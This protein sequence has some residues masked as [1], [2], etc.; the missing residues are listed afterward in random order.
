[1]RK[2]DA[3]ALLIATM[4]KHGLI[5]QG[6]GIRWDRAKQRAG[7]CNY[8]YRRISLS[9]PLFAHFDESAAT[10]VILHEVAHALTP[11]HGHD[12]VWRAKCIAIGGDGKRCC[13][14]VAA[15]KAIAKYEI[16]CS[17]TGRSLGFAN[18]KGKRLAA[19]RCRCCNQPPLWITQN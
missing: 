14:E 3:Q 18:R 6:W 12:R 16:K 7:Q 2:S 1:M 19:G 10:L 8:T 17:T 13:D 9:E 11:G 5:E 4:A 15:A